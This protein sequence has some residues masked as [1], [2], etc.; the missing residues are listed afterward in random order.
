[1]NRREL[2][3]LDRELTEF[4]GSM[5]QGMGRTERREA[6]AAYVTGLLL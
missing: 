3:K 2:R 5:V 6:L 4:I 1:M